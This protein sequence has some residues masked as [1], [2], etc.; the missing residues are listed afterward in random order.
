MLILS[1][2]VGE[3]IL[4]GDGIEVIVQRVAGDR[5]TLG[6]AAPREVKILRGELDYHQP[7][8]NEP[9]AVPVTQPSDASLTATGRFHPR[10]RLPR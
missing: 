2:K 5:V 10:N 3:R 8:I 6:L 4:I 1:R 9:V 7:L